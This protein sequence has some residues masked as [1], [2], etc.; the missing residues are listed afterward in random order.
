V[1]YALMEDDKRLVVSEYFLV[2]D[3]V[4]TLGMVTKLRWF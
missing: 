4:P 2:E 3:L 1:R